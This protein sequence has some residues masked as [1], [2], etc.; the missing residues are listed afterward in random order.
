MVNENKSNVFAAVAG[1]VVGA[2]AVIAGAVAMND[3]NNQRKVNDVLQKAKVVVNGYVD[4]VEDQKE[5]GKKDIKNVA[6]KAI[7]TA[8]Q[9]TKAVK[10]EVKKL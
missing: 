7:N 3:K 6:N 9:V 2:G 1:A 5:K 4:Q 10:K 8:E